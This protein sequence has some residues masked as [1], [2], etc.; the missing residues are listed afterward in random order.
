M[1]GELLMTLCLKDQWDTLDRMV[2]LGPKYHVRIVVV[3]GGL[4]SLRVFQVK[5]HQYIRGTIN[6]AII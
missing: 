2:N 5:S 3:L 4:V 6:H 1:V